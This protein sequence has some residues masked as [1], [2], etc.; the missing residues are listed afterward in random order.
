M[1]LR[2][3]GKVVEGSRFATFNTGLVDR[4]Y[5]PIYGLFERNSS[6]GN[7]PWKY[8]DF[9]VP[10]QGSAGKHLTSHISPLPPPA[11]YFE[12]STDLMLDVSQEIHVDYDHVILDGI[13]RGRFPSSFLQR[14]L[15]TSVSWKEPSELSVQDRA[16]FFEDLAKKLNDDV[17]CLR[18][19]KSRLEIAKSLAEKR[20]RWNFRTAIPQYYPRFDLISFLLP[21]SLTDDS[22][23]DIALVVT[24]NPSGSYQGRTILPLAWAYMN[25]RLVTRPDSDWLEPRMIGSETNEEEDTLQE[26]SSDEDE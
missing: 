24:R 17:Q 14:H 26:E 4:L 25:A 8:L 9:C 7:Q 5:D 16:K 12:S 20:T 21:L 13:A 11:V 1:K 2:R 19:I 22:Q 23:V 15:P 3:E 18:N 10:G 6:G